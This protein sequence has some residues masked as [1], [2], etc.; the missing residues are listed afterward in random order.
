MFIEEILIPKSINNGNDNDYIYLDTLKCD[1]VEKFLS[2]EKK[3]ILMNKKKKLELLEEN[4][5]KSKYKTH[6]NLLPTVTSY[7]KSVSHQYGTSKYLRGRYT[8]HF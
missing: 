8:I 7:F 1:N 4:H 3:C 5:T 2:F 6:Q